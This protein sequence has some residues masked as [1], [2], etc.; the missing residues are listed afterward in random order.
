MSNIGRAGTSSVL[1]VSVLMMLAIAI[2]I[3]PVAASAQPNPYPS[4][5][6]QSVNWPLQLPANFKLGHVV[7]ADLGPD[8]NI[9]VAHRCGLYQPV[10]E[11]CIEGTSAPILKLDPSGKLLK[12][13]GEGL[14]VYPNDLVFHREGNLWATD[15]IGEAQRT[16]EMDASTRQSD[17]EVRSGGESSDDDPH[18][19]GCWTWAGPSSATP[20]A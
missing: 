6:Y 2:A 18:A 4:N 12:A 9:Y 19:G 1:N 14:M 5:P 10:R 20:A 17:P 11:N 13:W 3:S 16:S 15:A 8:G 7:A